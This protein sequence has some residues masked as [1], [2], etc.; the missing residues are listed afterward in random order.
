M[1]EELGRRFGGGTPAAEFVV[2]SGPGGVVAT[3]SLNP[4]RWVGTP[5]SRTPF[6]RDGRATR[7]A[8]DLDGKARFYGRADV[9]SLGWSVYAGIPRSDAL[10]EA[11]E[12]M[13]ERA[14]LVVA[15]LVLLLLAAV[16]IRRR[17]AQ[18]VTELTRVIERTSAGSSEPAPVPRGP[19]ELVKLTE[20][21]NEM[22]GTQH[23]AEQTLRRALAEESAAAERLRELGELKD[24]F[25]TAVSH[26]L[27]TPLTTI[28]GA[29]STL[30]DRA[31]E[32]SPEVRDDLTARAGQ[33]ARK[34]EKLVR[35]L[36][37]LGSLQ[38]GDLEPARTLVDLVVL[39]EQAV[40]GLAVSSHPVSLDLAPV[41]AAV[42]P[43]HVARI[44]ENLVGNA[45]KHTPA[46]TPVSVRLRRHPEGA[47]LVVEDEGPGVP[48]PIKQSIF[49]TFRHVVLA[50]PEAQ[51]PA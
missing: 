7:A 39:I 14:L 49:E 8:E 31:H 2:V 26:E 23:A 13:R 27:R 43:V 30:R 33:Q 42:D 10:R 38:R 21:F 3:R 28:V 16:A 24:R 36:L 9:G 12:R 5:V 46:G 47:H 40:S 37:D 19:V 15:G 17:L 35:D 50:A 32:L 45:V 20:A 4:Q 6:G 1:G 29:T 51:G 34:L 48:D 41:E 18:P 11:G 22:R 44:V 25:L